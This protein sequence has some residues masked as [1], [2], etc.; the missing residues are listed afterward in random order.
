MTMVQVYVNCSYEELELLEQASR[1][2]IAERASIIGLGVAPFIPVPF[3]KPADVK[4]AHR[5][6]LKGIERES[7]A[8]LTKSYH[9]DGEVYRQD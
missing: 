6:L 4:R 8:G 3:A 9:I 7:V 2:I 5:E 1:R